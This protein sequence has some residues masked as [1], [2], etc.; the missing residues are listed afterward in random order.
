MVDC[1]TN[2]IS[3]RRYVILMLSQ[4]RSVLT[5]LRL[6]AQ[7]ETSLE[8]PVSRYTK[9]PRVMVTATQ[10]RG[11]PKLSQVD[12]RN[13]FPSSVAEYSIIVDDEKKLLHAFNVLVG[14]T[15]L[16]MPGKGSNPPF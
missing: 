8:L 13:A 15:A 5:A 14:M 3:P 12:T 2:F 10:A 9:D 1:L 6:L 11:A 4:T 7:R 16:V